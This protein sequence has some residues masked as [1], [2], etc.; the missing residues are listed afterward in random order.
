MRDVRITGFFG[1]LG[2]RR[3]MISLSRQNSLRG[4]IVVVLIALLF[5]GL[6]LHSGYLPALL[7]AIF[8]FLFLMTLS[9]CPPKDATTAA[10]ANYAGD[11]AP[12]RAPPT[13]FF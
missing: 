2:A 10:L 8:V 4:F 11:P 7:T 1:M 5:V 6:F 13:S 3:G 12:A 9:N